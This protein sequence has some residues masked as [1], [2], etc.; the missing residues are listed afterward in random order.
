M[1]KLIA[2][3]LDNVLLDGEAI[4]EI[5]KLMGVEKEISALTKEAMEGDLNFETSLKKRVSL[6]KGASLD[7]VKKVVAD[8]P[9]MEGAEETIKVLKQR[10]YKI[11][12]ITGNVEI[13]AQ[14]LK[15]EL[16]LDY[17]FCNIL[18]EKDGILTGEVS[19]PLLVE[20]SKADI[21]QELLDTEKLSAEDC[22][23]VGDGANDISMLKK[24]G[25]GVAFNAKPVVKE[26][27]DVIIDGK[28]L[29]ELLTIFSEEV[30]KEKSSFEIDTKKSFDVLLKEKRGLEKKLNEL[31]QER[32]KLNEEARTFK[33]LRDDLNSS[34][35]DNLDK[36]LN[37]RNERD[38]VNKEVK[39]YKKL[40]DEANQELKKMEW[41]SGKRDIQRVQDEIKKIDKV[42]ETQV[43]DIR[44]ENELVK[45]VSE[46]QKQLK[47]MKE[48][49]ET[50]E[51][52]VKLKE[53]SES[54]HARVVELSD[55]AQETHEQMIKYFEKIDDIRVKADEAHAEF[56]KI[57]ENA[58]QK[59]DEVKTLLKEIKAKN[60]A[61]DKVKAKKRYREDEVSHNENAKEKER[62]QEIYR[63]FLGGKKLST[64]ELLLLQK[65]NVV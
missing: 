49:E 32:D 14:R 6:L 65:H 4:D 21:L 23:A 30:K 11:A 53:L 62:A 17:A 59:H 24:A 28:D 18:H 12:T 19:G 41:S 46:L 57:R 25:L 55:Q 22:A 8:I 54:Y 48:N 2:F 27:A 51:E 43:L 56:M 10:G 35:K 1:I 42:I 52:A 60:K 15:D 39:K 33:H 26:I 50:R 44:K 63:K 3:D 16:N 45:Q 29:R 31:T 9:L 61:L 64:D 47:P 40:R 58:S 5:G 37:Y 7:D 38:Q 34:I 20:G 36:A 13:V